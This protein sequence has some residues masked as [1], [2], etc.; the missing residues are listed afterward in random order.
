MDRLGRSLRFYHLEFDKKP[1]LVVSW[2][3]STFRGGD[4]LSDFKELS[5]CGP[6]GP[7]LFYLKKLQVKISQYL[8][9]LILECNIGKV[10]NRH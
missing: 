4:I 1:F 10:T 5:F 8:H 3:T 9:G 7:W 6:C 2:H